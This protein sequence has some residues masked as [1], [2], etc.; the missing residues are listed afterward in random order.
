MV[1]RSFRSSSSAYGGA[2]ALRGIT[3]RVRTF[4]LQAQ[5]GARGIRIESALHGFGHAVEEHLFD[6]H[7]IMEVLDMTRRGHSATDVSMNGRRGVRGERD[8]V[9]IGKRGGFEKTRD[10][11]ASCG[12]GLQDVDS[13]GS[14]H[15][16]KIWAVIAVFACGDVH[17]R[18]SLI[19]KE[20]QSFQVVGRNGLLKP[21]H[22]M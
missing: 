14:E 17:A 3:Y 10:S 21:S 6:A 13:A 12:V 18:G 9:R 16:S 4:D 5:S 11:G 22:A 19:A 15:S 7:V 8:V 1:L 20:P 2:G